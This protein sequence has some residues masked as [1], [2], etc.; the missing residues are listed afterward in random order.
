MVRCGY[1][2]VFL[3]LLCVV[4]I[5]TLAQKAGTD[6]NAPPPLGKL[7]DVGGYRVHLYCIGTG[8]PTVVI[9]G[10][11]FSFNWGLVQPEVAGFTQVCSYDHSGIGWSDDGPKDSCSLRVSEVHTALKNAGIKGPYVLV[12]HSLGGL[13]ARVYAGQYPDEVAGMVFVDHAF[14]F[15]LT[16]PPGDAKVSP[17]QHHRRRLRSP[18][19]EWELRVIRTSVSYLRAIAS[20][21]CGLWHR[22]E[23][24][25]YC[26]Q[27][28]G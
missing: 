10:A 5:A 17:P 14:G 1:L 3:A 4:P 25:P 27:T 11:G 13:V 9:V 19:A 2:T 12:G 18:P 22:P 24:K 16:P 28:Y 6:P 15:P 20:F 8:S 7:V 26:G 23:I 21:T